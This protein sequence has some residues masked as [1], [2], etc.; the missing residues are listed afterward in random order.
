MIQI[1]REPARGGGNKEERDEP[2]LDPPPPPPPSYTTVHM[3]V[4][5]CTSHPDYPNRVAGSRGN[6][7]SL[8]VNIYIYRKE[9]TPRRHQLRR[10]FPV[11]ITAMP[12]AYHAVAVCL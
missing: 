7:R 10:L 3:Y 2:N 6:P 1:W 4:L 11:C 12:A 5:Y 8:S 9:D